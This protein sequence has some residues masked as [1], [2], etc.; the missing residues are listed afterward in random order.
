MG[1]FVYIKNN[2]TKAH[3]LGHWK[4]AKRI[5]V[6]TLFLSIGSMTEVAKITGVPYPTIEGWRRQDWWKELV[7]KMQAEDDQKL[8]AKTTKLI[9]KALEQLMDRI[10]NGEHI[11]D[12][13]T[14]KV[15]RM[16]AKLRDLN[17]AFNTILDKRQLLR[18]Q[19]TKIIEQQSTALQLQNLANQFAGFVNKAVKELPDQ[20]YIENDTVIQNED[21]VWEV[22]E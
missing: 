5:E 16:P 3:Q 4:E 15:K 22:K 12:Q 14:G 19:P 17:T 10:E 9:D 18:R 21:G 7:E 8:D 6:V 13:K 20:H 11:Y 2:K 1:K